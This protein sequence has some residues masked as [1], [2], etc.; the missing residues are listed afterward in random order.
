MTIAVYPQV[1]FAIPGTAAADEASGSLI[2]LPV[3]L[4]TRV[5]ETGKGAVMITANLGYNLS[6]SA[7]TRD[8]ISAAFGIGFPL[9]SSIAMMVEANTEQSLGTNMAGVRE[10]LYKANAGF[11]GKINSHLLWFGAVG[12]SYAASD[13]G[14]TTH[15]CLI[16]GLRL[17]A[18]GP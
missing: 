17:I 16:A 15:T 10:S 11:L 4:A 14:D 13:A 6:T 12:E 2:K 18:G 5:G 7:D 9:T 3:L 1:E 8:Y